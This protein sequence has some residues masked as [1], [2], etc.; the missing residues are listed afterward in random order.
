MKLR[1]RKYRLGALKI[2]S[3]Y[4]LIGSEDMSSQFEENVAILY[5]EIEKDHATELT[6]RE[7]KLVYMGYFK[8]FMEGARRTTEI[9]ELSVNKSNK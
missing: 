4:N 6:D 8:G 1:L 9:W 5:R 2:S 7:K 3:K